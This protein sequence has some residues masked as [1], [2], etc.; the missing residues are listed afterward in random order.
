MDFLGRLELQLSGDFFEDILVPGDDIIDPARVGD[1]NNGL[2]LEE[3]VHGD[4]DE[5][6]RFPHAFGG[7]QD[8]DLALSQSAVNGF[9]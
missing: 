5:A 7:G 1:V 9:F 8:T 3:L 6:G 2:A 4:M